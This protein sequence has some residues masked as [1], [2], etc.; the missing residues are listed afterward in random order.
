MTTERGGAGKGRRAGAPRTPVSSPSSSSS[1][2]AS[3]L[4]SGCVSEGGPDARGSGVTGPRRP[5]GVTGSRAAAGGGGGGG[6]DMGVCL[7]SSKGA[8]ISQ[9][10][11]EAVLQ[12]EPSPVW[13]WAS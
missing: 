6:A 5:S 8:K 7:P 2:S 3:C 13:V 12:R 10:T 11:G 4:K 1:P 9:R